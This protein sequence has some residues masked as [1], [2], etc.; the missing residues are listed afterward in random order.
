[1]FA[2]PRHRS[3]PGAI[4]RNRRGQSALWSYGVSGDLPVVLVRVSE[5]ANLDLVRRMIQAHAYWRH[6]GLDS[7]LV[8]WTEA[9][10]GYRQSLLDA[11]IG[12]VHGGAGARMLDQPGGIF[13][14]SVDQVPE[15]DRALFQAV[16]RIVISEDRK[17][18]V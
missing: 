3:G 10:S 8:I 11:A 15:E 1:M 7:E 17:S 2:N 18:V 4:A 12:L 13:V 14:R 6:K 5:D 16:A 9:F